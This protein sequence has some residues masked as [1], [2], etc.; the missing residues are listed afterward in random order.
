[1][2]KLT[3]GEKKTPV[4]GATVLAYHLSLAQLFRSEPTGENGKFVIEGL[5]HGYFD[6]AVDSPDGIYVS[7][8]VV[9]AGPGAEV[10]ANFFLAPSDFAGGDPREFPGSSEPPIG[11]AEFMKKKSKKAISE[12]RKREGIIPTLSVRENMILAMQAG[13]G[14]LRKLPKTRQLEIADHYIT[15]LNIKTPSPETPVENLSGGNQQKV[16]LAR[17][18]CLQPKLIILDEPTRGIDVGAKVEIEKLVESLRVDGMGILFISSELEEVVR[19]CSRVAVM[20]DHRKAGELEG[21]KI[22]ET[23]IMEMIASHEGEGE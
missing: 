19:A 1:M 16:L 8:Q 21:A 13:Q 2:G 20:R 12:D 7:E 18:L 11:I 10:V 5:P 14:L 17:W 22:V 4:V 15:A 3:I 23:T 9:N 6:M